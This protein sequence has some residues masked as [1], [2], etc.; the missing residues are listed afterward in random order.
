MSRRVANKNA[1]SK[2]LNLPFRPRARLLQLLG[3]ELI[4]SSRLA[5]FELVKNAYD[6]DA[7]TVRIV[8][9]NID[10]SEA[11]I[12][13]E[14][15]GEGMTL[16]TIRNIWL[17]PGHDHRARQRAEMRRTRRGRLPLGEKGLGRFAAHKL[18]NRIEVVT[19]ADEQP[20]C[21][22]SIDWNVLNPKSEPFRCDGSGLD[23]RAD[24]IPRETHRNTYHDLRASRH[25]LDSR[26]GTSTPASNYDH[27]LP[28]FRCLG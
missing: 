4:G 21:V 1:G 11:S 8:L 18:G 22:V 19:R 16:D 15:D 27:L 6:A 23:T 14:D 28:I 3:D 12:V 9:E 10:S 2:A 5:V 20:E 24:Q 25:G 17:V 7:E 26:R 13:V